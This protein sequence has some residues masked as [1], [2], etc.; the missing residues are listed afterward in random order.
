MISCILWTFY[1]LIN[2]L[3]AKFLHPGDDP[4]GCLPTV[5]IGVAGSFI[6]GMIN[7]MLG[8][9]NN[10]YHPAGILMSTVGS[11]LLLMGWRYYKLNN[12]K[13]GPKSFFTGRYK[14]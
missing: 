11:I 2:G 14:S 3:L 9:G 13:S 8:M 1:G 4:V 5:F 7:Y 6:G 12:S 10:P